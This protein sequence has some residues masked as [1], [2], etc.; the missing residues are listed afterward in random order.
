MTKPAFQRFFDVEKN[1]LEYIQMCEGMDGSFLIE[2]LKKY[3]KPN[4]TILELGTGPGTDLDILKKNYKAT[5]SDYSQ[6]FLNIYKEKN[7]E[8]DLILLDAVTLE[9]KRKFDGIYSNKVLH[10]LSRK[11]LR[12]SLKKQKELL[13]ENGILFHTFWHGEKEEEFQALR[14]IQYK[15][16]ELKELTTEDYELIKIKTYEEMNINDSI[17]VILRKL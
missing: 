12:K 9:T 4:S 3:L 1:V 15:M 7:K 5:G 6:I 2:I 10:H 11:D 14:F 8:A 13:K 16:D 17:F